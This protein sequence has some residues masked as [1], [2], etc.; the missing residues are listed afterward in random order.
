MCASKSSGT[1][2]GLH[3]KPCKEL[4]L[5]S[6]E[7]ERRHLAMELHDTLGQSLT[8]IQLYAHAIITQP[9][10]VPLAVRSAAES[11]ARA[12]REIHE[13]IRSMTHSLNASPLDEAGLLTSLHK[14]LAKW[15]AHNP[16][17][18]CHL[19]I[20]EATGK[21]GECLELVVYR[22]V[23]ESLTNVTRHSGA[24]RVRVELRLFGAKEAS[25]GTLMLAVEDNGTGIKLADGHQGVGLA[26]MKERVASVKGSLE[27]GRA[28][29]GGLRVEA[30]FPL[31]QG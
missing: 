14:M 22:V 23:Q 27:L 8:G 29:G 28:T 31:G 30:R 5:K 2:C 20:S 21:L 3:E 17:V 7:M 25:P 13:K 16:G 26:G 10:G 24:S 6:L 1:S 4:M 19:D 9:S 18:E 12:G 11:I 15:G